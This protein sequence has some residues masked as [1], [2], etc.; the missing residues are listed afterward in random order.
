MI[1]NSSEFLIFFI[2]VISIFFSI[3][4]K[5]RAIFLLLVSYIFYAWWN[6]TYLFLILASTLTDYFAAKK[7]YQL[8]KKRDRRNWLI[9]SILVNIGILFT[10][11]YADFFAR[12][13]SITNH[14]NKL[15]DFV[16]PVGISFYT[17]QTLS[18]TIDVYRKKIRPETNLVK[19]SLFVAFF[20]QLVAGPIERADKILPQFNFKRE[21]FNAERFTKGGILMLWGFYQKVV[22]ADN[23]SI[24]VDTVY[25]NPQHYAGINVAIATLFFA[26]QIYCDFAGYT[27]IARGIAKIMNI[28]LSV[29]FRQPYFATSIK[30]FWHRWHITLSRWFKDY[31]YIP[32]GGS[33]SS[34]FKWFVAI[35]ITF[36][37]SGLWH[38]ANTTFIIW[39]AL[40]GGVYIVEQSL[41]QNKEQKSKLKIFLHT[42]IT[43]CI[44]VFLWIFF[45]ANTLSGASVIINNLF[46]ADLHIAFDY[47]WLVVNNFLIVSVLLVDL[48]EVK[49]QLY[50]MYYSSRAIYQIFFVGY[51]FLMLLFVG[52]W[53]Q[54]PFI[55]F[56]F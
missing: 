55:Y 35:F 22:V 52:N 23:L 11:K 3:P 53:H 17:F 8:Y 47:K 43:F 21:K 28:E 32:L 44:V 38:G 25:N 4:A 30:D 5:F 29:N 40:F 19:F 45:R 27:N 36:T 6:W 13:F 33:K 12:I 48:I 10:F 24:F 16:L 41:L 56:Q 14:S 42:T 50:E 2:V 34:K 15:L 51:L 1:F 31:V 18:Y 39:G 9:F 26:F 37:V 7:I 54:T 49:Q 46:V 20:P